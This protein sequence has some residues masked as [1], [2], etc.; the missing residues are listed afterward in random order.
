V[1]TTRPTEQP[2]R[3][4]TSA[5]RPEAIRRHNLALILGHVHRDGALTRAELTQRLAVSRSTVG[6][7]VSDLTALGLVE[8]SVPSGGDRVGRPSHVVGPHSSG[9][10]A[11]AVDVDVRHISSAGIGLN[12]EVLS[13]RTV[14][15]GPRPLTPEEV[16]GLIADWTEELAHDSGRPVTGVGVSVPGT[17]DRRTTVG[18]APNLGWR[19]A[20]LGA[21]LSDRLSDRLGDSQGSAWTVTV[22]NDADLSLLAELSRGHATGCQDVVYL[23]GRI[24]VGAGVVVNGAP[25]RGRDGRAGEI[26]HNVVDTNGPECHC[27]KHG[28]LETI[29]GD[30]ALLA[31]AGRDGPPTAENVAAMFDAA[32]TGEERALA[33]VHSAAG[34]LGQALGTLVNLLNPQRVILG[35]S[36]AGVLELARPEIEHA[37]ERYAFDPGHPVELVSPRFGSDAALLGAAEL[38]FR[39]LLED[40]Y[41]ARPSALV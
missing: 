23:I 4:A 11:V 15:T 8:E 32:R 28:C 12:G 39:P 40:P 1:T 7:L 6:A 27:G 41:A 25:V 5:A 22:G 14:A 26:G 30:A 18:V 21:L 10:F 20:P 35:G 38:A 36:L 31:L 3:A 29:I 37:L 9:P 24:G 2:G 16:A 19:D 17:V 34:W 13:R 33:A